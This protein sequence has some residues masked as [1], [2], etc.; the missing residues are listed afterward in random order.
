MLA[1]LVGSLTKTSLYDVRYAARTIQCK[2]ANSH[3]IGSAIGDAISHINAEAVVT[4]NVVSNLISI[5]K[6]GRFVVDGLKVENDLLAL[7]IAGN[8]KGGLVP[9]VTDVEDLQAGETTLNA[10]RNHDLGVKRTS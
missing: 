6:D 9:H 10:R 2:T 5:D 8:L 1:E 3:V 7:P 4:T